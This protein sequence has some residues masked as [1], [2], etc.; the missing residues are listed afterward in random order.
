MGDAK[1]CERCGAEIPRAVGR[2]KYSP[3]E[4]AKR[5]VCSRACARLGPIK[6][7]GPSRRVGLDE[8]ACLVCGTGFVPADHRQVTCAARKCQQRLQW[9]RQ[10]ERPAAV[11]RNRARNRAWAERVRGVTGRNPW[12]WGEPALMAH[13]PGESCDLWVSGPPVPPQ[14][15]RALHGAVSRLLGEPHRDDG[16]PNF[17]L[18]P[19][20]RVGGPW[21][22]H[23]YAGG[24]RVAGQTFTG[25]SE[26]PGR[27][28]RPI[29][30]DGRARSLRFGAAARVPSPRLGGR[31]GHIEVEVTTITPVLYR[32]TGGVYYSRVTPPYLI[33]LLAM[34]A[35]RVLGVGR[36]EADRMV[37]LEVRSL[38]QSSARGSIGGHW[39]EDRPGHFVHFTV[40][41]VANAPTVWL[42]KC[43]EALGIGGRTSLGFG[44]I[45]VTVGERN[46]L[47]TAQASHNV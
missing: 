37:R 2:R 39:D 24:G 22:V 34:F 20:L 45:G 38:H 11:A 21:R 8:K 5:R 15:V 13:L 43:A 44:R 32:R 7:I 18:C 31:R 23:L 6:A 16:L 12:L 35:R 17:S 28:P 25:L 26:A 29:L 42:L 10:R 3:A 33:A 30:I 14:H 19:P 47:T 40:R 41:V 27:D 4:Y 1:L 9:V 36:Q 46:K